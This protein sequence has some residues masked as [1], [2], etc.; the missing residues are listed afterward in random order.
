MWKNRQLLIPILILLMSS[1]AE[2]IE[3]IYQYP[4][5]SSFD[6]CA[7][8]RMSIRRYQIRSNPSWL[9]ASLPK[10]YRLIVQ[11]LL[12]GR[13]TITLDEAITIVRENERMMT[14]IDGGVSYGD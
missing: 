6:M 4:D 11:T 2:I 13:K 7:S 10:S 12:M 3:V 8:C 5:A 1:D 14:Q 9:L